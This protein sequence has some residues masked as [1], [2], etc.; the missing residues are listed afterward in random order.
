[1]KFTQTQAFSLSATDLGNHLGCKHLTELNRA[2]AKGKIASPKWYDPD[3][4]RIRELGLTHEKA[5]VDHLR[6][7]GLQVVELM[8]EDGENAF[9]RTVAAMQEGKDVIVQAAL[10]HEQWNGRADI[11][12]RV[13]ES[14]ELGDWSYEVIDTKLAQNTK[15]GTVLQLC[16]YSELVGKI[17]GRMPSCMHVAKPG[18]AFPCESFLFAEFKA[19]Y[20]L[21]QNQLESTISTTP[22]M[23]YPNPVPH[24]D[25]CHWWKECD[26]KRRTDDH[27]N[28]VAGMTSLHQTELERQDIKALTQFAELNEALSEKPKYGTLETYSKLHAQARIQLEGRQKEE[29]VYKLLPPEPGYGFFRLPEPSKGDVFFDIESDAFV[30]GRGLEYLLGFVYADD[31]GS[32]QYC[33]H[34]AVDRTQEKRAFEQFIDSVTAHWKKHPEMYIYH[35]SHYDPSA[36]KRL[37]GRHNT[38]QIELDEL[39]RGER[40][41]DLHAVAK[42]GLLASVES[43]GLKELEK[44]C[45]FKRDV[46]L[47]TADS[48]RRRVEYILELGAASELTDA[49]RNTVQGYNQDDCFATLALR[50][51][52]EERRKELLEQGHDTPRPEAKDEQASENVQERLQEIKAVYERLL[53]DLP[54]DSA[55]FSPEDQHKWLLAQLLTYFERENKSAWWEFFRLRDLDSGALLEE[56]KAVTGLEFFKSIEPTGR[57]RVPIHCY[58]FPYQEAAFDKGKS[59]CQPGGDSIGSV[60]LLDNSGMVIEIKKQMKTVQV[61]PD[62]VFVKEIVEPYPLDHSVLELARYVADHGV[63]VDGPFR[64][65]RDLL[66]KSTP[67][68]KEPQEGALHNPAE[69]ILTSSVRLAGSLDHGVLAIQGPPGTGK[70]YTAA[71][72]IIELAESGNRIGVTAIGHKVIRSL[73]EETLKAAVERDLTLE[74]VHKDNEIPDET[75]EG[76]TVEKNN[77]KALASLDE[78][79]I[80]GGTAW[81]WARDDAAEKLDY[82]FVDEAGQ[83]SLAH[84]LAA[85][86]STRNLILIG[87]PQ[88]L[89]QPQ[90]GAHPDGTEIDALSHLLDGADT[91]PD[92]KGLFIETTR[93]LHPYIA[94][95]TSEQYY[96]GRLKTLPGLERQAISGDTSF[97]GSGLF[98]VPVT[99]E[100]NQNSSLEE[101]EAAAKIVADLLKPGIEWI[102]EKG[103]NK[104]LRPKDILIV[105]PYNAQVGALQSRLPEI[106]IGTVDKFQG[107]EAPVVIYSMASS[108]VEDAP[109]GMG[110]LYSPNRLNVATSRARCI[111]ILVAAPRLLEP[112]CRTPEQMRWANGLC[113]FRELA[114][115]VNL[116][117]Y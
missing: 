27:L 71:R 91:I 79:K 48:A 25:I 89:E 31:D 86:R 32:W 19:Y 94:E 34:W 21:V 107:Q 1:M 29:L 92:D 90:K 98:Y 65:A 10:Q 11:L 102:D 42:Q 30:E 17:Q 105:A 111:C 69:D 76:L 66:I 14:S 38:R 5:F 40:F 68:L 116:V 56:R 64:A 2:L 82:L 54:D 37:M 80:V 75:Y 33:A 114:T 85:A 110:F 84:V 93:R 70:T 103:V 8:D 7:K 13:A 4:A 39:L 45:K 73:L 99:H 50:D 113:R 12:Y 18:D 117:T 51:W 6:N 108:S 72:M 44:F 52:L 49:D 112:E 43:Y 36:L 57:A 15:G 67:R 26:T 83:M 35:F 9:Q 3:S 88:Q 60:N 22:Q 100:G 81:L 97:A 101:V 74:A 53:A 23:I 55:L 104:E 24:C 61:H 87:D 20:H 47:K 109:R 58:R 115:V 28:L 77:E 59:L 78:G 41:V 95:F 46:D 96:E 106:R 16:L 62:A 63:D